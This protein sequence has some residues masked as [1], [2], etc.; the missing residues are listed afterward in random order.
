[1]I[2]GRDVKATLI[3]FTEAANRAGDFKNAS[4][5]AEENY[6][7]SVNMQTGELQHLRAIT[8]GNIENAG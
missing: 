4:S 6:Q 1:V 2:I 8:F 5:S 3:D 7:S